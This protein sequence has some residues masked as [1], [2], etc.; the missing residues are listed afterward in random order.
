MHKTTIFLS[1][2]LVLA[3]GC[4]KKE[5]KEAEAI[6]PVEVT[7][8]VQATIHRVIEADAVL[9]PVDQSAVMPKISAPV[10]KFHV[11]RGDHVKAGQLL[12]VLEARDLV[13]TAAA[14]KGQVDQAE[15]NLRNTTDATVPEAVTKAVTDVQSFEQQ[16][17]AAQKLLESRQKLYTDGALARRQVDEAQV[18]YSAAKAQLEAAQEHLRALQNVAKGEQIRQAKAQV[19]SAQGQ[20][21]S[22][23]AQVGYAEIRSPIGGVVADRPLYAGE[24]ASPGNPLM[25]IVD[26]SR[27]VARANVPQNQATAVKVGDPATIRLTDAEIEVPGRVTVVS[28]ATDPAT[29]TVQVWVQADNPGEKLKPG[30]GAHVSIVVATIKDAAVVPVAAILPGEE[31]GTAVIAVSGGNTAHKKKVEVGVREG[32]KVQIVSGVSP[33]EQVVSVGGIGLEDKAKVRIV[34]PGQK[35]EEEKPSGEAGSK[36]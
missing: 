28:P 10:L 27:V 20:F 9:Y 34:Q 3:S 14:S 30:A 11:N 16:L 4:S 23:E 8:V 29:T 17:A 18:A 26:I 12:A 35:E 32:D 31:G 1:A 13:A 36:K 22:A 33:G 5:E 21:R 7:P 19:E 24:M 2:L 25:T 15:A 6:A